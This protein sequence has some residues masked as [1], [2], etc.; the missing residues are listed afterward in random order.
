MSMQLLL[1]SSDQIAASQLCPHGYCSETEV[2]H[3]KFLLTYD[4]TSRRVFPFLLYTVACLYASFSCYSDTSHY[5]S[6]MWLICLIRG[7]LSLREQSTLQINISLHKTPAKR[8]RVFKLLRTDS[9]D[10]K[11]RYDQAPFVE[12]NRFLTA[13]I[14]VIP[15]VKDDWPPPPALR[16]PNFQMQNPSLG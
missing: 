4:T 2:L 10:Y 1:R 15:L 8:I 14:K 12:I 13:R 9:N 7:D 11:N 5:I 16:K 6:P 3:D